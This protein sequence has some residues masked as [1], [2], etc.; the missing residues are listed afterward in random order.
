MGFVIDL[1]IIA[2]IVL[3]TYLAYRKGLVALAIQLCAIIISI[4]VT[5]VLYK[6]ISNFI[7]NT[8]NIDETIKNSIIEKAFEK[9]DKD[10]K[11]ED[12]TTTLVK[13]TEKNAIEQTAT[14]LSIQIINIG[15]III[16]YFGIKIA[17]KFVTILADKVASLPIINRFNKAGGL[18][19]G[20]I[21]GFVI[22]YACLLLIGFI[23]KIDA[24]NYLHENVEKSS[25]GKMMYENNV[26]NILF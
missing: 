9:A 23:G 8:T 13:N 14:D 19:F 26:F 18:F 22:V 17:L 15:V 24:S 1:I 2:I 6:P 16:L 3:S 5:L 12:I 7:I 20:L 10:N 4:V 11:Q 21:R 25:I